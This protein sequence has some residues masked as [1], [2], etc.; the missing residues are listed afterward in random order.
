M[1]LSDKLIE[2][3]GIDSDKDILKNKLTDKH[4]PLD[5]DNG[6]LSELKSI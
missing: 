1:A 2:V 4:C 5:C 3:H 6:M